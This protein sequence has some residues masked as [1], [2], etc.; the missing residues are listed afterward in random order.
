MLRKV[1]KIWK[2]PEQK[3]RERVVNGVDGIFSEEERSQKD[4][5]SCTL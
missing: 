2:N 3:T 1:T 4:Y 5:H